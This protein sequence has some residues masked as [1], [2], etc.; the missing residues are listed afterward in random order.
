MEMKPSLAPNPRAHRQ[1]KRSTD[2]GQPE[3]GLAGQSILTGP[4]PQG[5]CPSILPP[6]ARPELWGSR[7]TESQHL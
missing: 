4:E 3:A 7:V 2:P 1:H 5:V 6:C